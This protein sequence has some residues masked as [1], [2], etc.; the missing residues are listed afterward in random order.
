MN[1]DALPLVSVIIPV[2]NTEKYIEDC[3]FSVINQSYD[4]L[5]IIIV[6]DG[7][8]DGSRSII[9]K[10]MEVRN[11]AVNITVKKMGGEE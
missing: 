3:I 5:E 2:F 11:T 4:Q 10:Y 8:T 7:S 6:N 9:Q 1:S